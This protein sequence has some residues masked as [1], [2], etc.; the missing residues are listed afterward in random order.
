[1]TCKNQEKTYNK[2]YDFICIWNIFFIKISHHVRFGLK[3]VIQTTAA[4]MHRKNSVETAK[5]RFVLKP[6]DH[7]D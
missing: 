3:L 4:A 6:S 2:F 1:M 7:V 5:N